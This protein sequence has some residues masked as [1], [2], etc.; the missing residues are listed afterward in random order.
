MERRFFENM[1]V[2]ADDPDENGAPRL[3]CRFAT[4]TGEYPLPWDCYER[5]DP[6][7]FDETIGDDI[8][9]LWNHDSNIVLGRT[10]SGT[11]SLSI[12]ENEGLDGDTVINT[13]D[14]AAMDGYARV[15]RGDVTGCSI[16]FDILADHIEHR[17]DGKTGFVIDKIKLY[18]CSVCTF[19]AYRDTSAAVRDMSGAISKAFKIR[20]KERLNN[21]LKSS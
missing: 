7:A 16:G 21:A 14:R 4:F 12:A 1:I 6:H 20:M 2:R 19:P 11:A 18:E 13:E 3:H 15:K 8:R 10:A 17:S 9:I 5:I